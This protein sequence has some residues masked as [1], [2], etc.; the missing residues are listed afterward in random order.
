MKKQFEF[1]NIEN[2]NLEYKIK[3]IYPKIFLFFK[4]FMYIIINRRR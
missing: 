3:N 2:N 1:K 4:S